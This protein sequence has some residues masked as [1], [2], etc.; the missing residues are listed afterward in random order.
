[1]RMAFKPIGVLPRT[2]GDTRTMGKLT[3][4]DVIYTLETPY[5][6]FDIKR[7][8]SALVLIDIQRIASPEPFVKAAIK[9]GLPEKDVREAVADYDKRFWQAVENAARILKVCRLKGIEVV[10]V[11]LEAPTKN[12]LH[13]AKVNRKIGLVVQPAS[14]E[15]Q[16]LDAVKPLPDELVVAKTN[17]G[18][19]SGTNL[20]FVLRNMDID[21]LILVGFLTDE[22][23]AATAYHASDIGYDV[24][25]V[26]DACATHRKEAHDAIIWSLDDMCLKVYTTEEVLRKLET[27]PNLK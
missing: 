4:E 24:L 26:R 23:V 3:I 21:S 15:S 13:T 27:L 19:F 17:G 12:P 20:D 14:E 7:G 9:K 5:P 16:S 18:A 22:C 1:L 25:L 2:I 6:D 8:K 11:V 10:H